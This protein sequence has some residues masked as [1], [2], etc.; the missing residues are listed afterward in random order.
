MYCATIR[1]ELK[2]IKFGA[3]VHAV[4]STRARVVCLYDKDANAECLRTDDGR[5]YLGTVSQTLSGRT[6][7]R[8]DSQFP[9]QHFYTEIEMF[10]DYSVN[11]DHDIA[12]VSNYCRSPLAGSLYKA[13]PWC[14][15]VTSNISNVE[16]EFCSIPRCKGSALFA[17]IR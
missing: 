14:Y 5:Q 17:D 8:W 11:P 2:V 4:T 6:C 9:H 15:V 13:L 12:D 3:V 10:P 1:G 16:W 7:Q